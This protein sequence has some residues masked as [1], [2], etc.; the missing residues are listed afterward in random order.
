MKYRGVVVPGVLNF[1]KCV[2]L[3]LKNNFWLKFTKGVLNFPKCV[4][5]ALKTTFL[6][7][8][9]KIDKESP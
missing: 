5:L 3:A 7:K 6:D 8:I 2:F 1:P 9:D 4:F